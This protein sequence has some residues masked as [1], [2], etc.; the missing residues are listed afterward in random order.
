MK[1]LSV[2]TW[3]STYIL[4]PV[5]HSLKPETWTQVDMDFVDIAPSSQIWVVIKMPPNCL[6]SSNCPTT[7]LPSLLTSSSALCTRHVSH[8]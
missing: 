6:L 2:E 4:S 8:H 3:F 7:V 1:D 5:S